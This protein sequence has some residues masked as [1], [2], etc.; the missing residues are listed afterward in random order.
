MTTKNE[1]VLL[2]HGLGRTALSMW[3]LAR[4]LEAAGYQTVRWQYNSVR[5]GLP[6]IAARLKARLPELAHV[7]KLHAVGHSMGG[8][9]LRSILADST[10]PLGRLVLLGVPNLGAKIIDQ[11]GWLFN[12]SFCPTSINDMRCNST[13]I[14]TLP[15]P[16]MEI[17][18]V[19]GVE[20][21]NAV[22][23]ASWLNKWSLGDA[24]HDGTVELSS[25]RGV[26][27]ADYIEVPVNHSFLPTSRRVAP[28]V[29]RFIETGKFT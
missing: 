17:G 22:N 2:L 16:A 5:G 4:A 12:R 23:P 10:L 7:N 1:T 9:L 29:V 6:A 8:L 26:A 13:Y 19:S 24:P 20:K 14:Q 25:A 15:L 3:P 27:A 18:V 11:H 28:A 21:F